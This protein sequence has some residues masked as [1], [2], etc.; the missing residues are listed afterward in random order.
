MACG[1]PAI[2][3]RRR[4]TAEP[5]RCPPC[6]GIPTS[7]L[8][9]PHAGLLLSLSKLNRK[10]AEERT[11]KKRFAI[12]N[13]PHLDFSR[14]RSGFHLIQEDVC[15]SMPSRYFLYMLVR[16]I[17][18][19]RCRMVCLPVA[20]HYQEMNHAGD[21]WLLF[22]ELHIHINGCLFPRL[23]GMICV[24]FC[25]YSTRTCSHQQMQIHHI[26][27]SFLI[28]WNDV[29]VAYSYM[30]VYTK[31][32]PCVA[33]VYHVVGLYKL[34]CIYPKQCR[35]YWYSIYNFHFRIHIP[36]IVVCWIKKV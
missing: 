1:S 22:C 30:P 11:A 25:S 19:Q 20:D 13:F 15:F 6:P 32:I 9:A 10:M 2:H 24:S 4:H 18:Q 3:C 35:F 34:C 16:G 27:L 14:L 23:Q 28:G 21:I 26:F 5:P 17:I 33:H 8:V 12:L 31:N 7:R 29:L 36:F